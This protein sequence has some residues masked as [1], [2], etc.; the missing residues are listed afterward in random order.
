[1]S[2]RKSI[3]QSRKR[4]AKVLQDEYWDCSVCTYTN[5][6]E[7][8]KCSICDVRKGTSTRKP[9][10]NQH[11]VAQQEATRLVAQMPQGQLGKEFLI[12]KDD[13]E[14][15]SIEETGCKPTKTPKCKTKSNDQNLPFTM[16]VTVNNVTV[17]FTELKKTRL[18][19]NETSN[20]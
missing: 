2:D 3:L 14:V 13:E 4:I 10:L 17:M 5:S 1:M 19:V 20:R 16:A 11:I 15:K 8:F 7:A 9:R 12:E 6:P 18:E